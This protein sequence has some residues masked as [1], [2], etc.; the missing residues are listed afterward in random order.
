MQLGEIIG[1]FSEEARASEALLACNDIVLLARVGEAAFR[2]EETVGEYAAGAVRRFA[3]LAVSE[4]W[5]ALMNVIERADD[6]GIGCLNYMVHWSLKQ[7]ET[8]A[9]TAH[10]GCTCG[11]SGGCS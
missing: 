10:A 7:D 8:P 1:S 11:D 6:P 4:D 2:H 9:V 3:N 5:L